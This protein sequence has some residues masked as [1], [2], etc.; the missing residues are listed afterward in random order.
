MKYLIDIMIC[1]KCGITQNNIITVDKDFNG[2]CFTC[3]EY[4]YSCRKYFLSD[5]NE[6]KYKDYV[7]ICRFKEWCSE[8][9]IKLNKET[10]K[11][12]INDITKII[13]DYIFR[14]Q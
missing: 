13:L 9:F 11:H 3:S 1:Y 14:V 2:Y 12:V 8:C 4:C 7:S 6:N 5:S 10:N